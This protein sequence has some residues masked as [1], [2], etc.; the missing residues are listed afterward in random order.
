MHN[1]GMVS[2]FRKVNRH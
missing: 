1:G 2:P